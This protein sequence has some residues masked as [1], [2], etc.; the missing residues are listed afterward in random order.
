MIAVS[1][2]ISVTYASSFKLEDR[3]LEVKVCISDDLGYVSRAEVRFNRYG[4]NEGFDGTETMTFVGKKDNKSEFIAKKQI[5]D[6]G[7]ISF[8]I[9]VVINNKDKYITRDYNTFEPVLEEQKL[10][11]WEVF[12]YKDNYC[13]PEE[14]DG[15]I[16]YQVFVDTY[17]RQKEQSKASEKMLS[18]WDDP[19]QWKPDEKGDYYSNQF[20]GGNIKGIVSKLDHIKSL[21]TTALY[22]TPVLKSSTNHRYAT[23]DYEMVDE[24]VGLWEDLELLKEECHKRGMV[25]ILDIVFNHSGRYNRLMSEH[26]EMYKWEN[27]E[28]KCWWDF[29]ELPE[30]NQN[31][32]EF[33]KYVENWIKEHAKYVDGFRVDVADSLQDNVRKLMRRA[34][35]DKYFLYEVWK[36]AV[37]GDGKK[38]ID[39]TEGDAVMNY[40]FANAIYSYILFGNYHRAN[41]IIRRVHELYPPKAMNGCPIFLSS[42]DIPH[43]INILSGILISDRYSENVWDIDKDE[44]FTRNGRFDTYEFRKWESQHHDIPD[45]MKE[46]VFKRL[47]LA[48]LMEY[49][50]PGLPCIYNGEE[51]GVTG[52][53]DPFNRTPM[54]WKEFETDK[55]MNTIYSMYLDIGRF[56]LKYKEIFKDSTNFKIVRMDGRLMVYRRGNL[57]I[58]INRSDETVYYPY[59]SQNVVFAY[60][61]N[62]GDNRIPEMSAIVVKI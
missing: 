32:P 17:C 28:I 34:A 3:N 50:L 14:I 55:E 41:K 6:T 4:S 15:G 12:V 13:L 39:G 42:H 48:L 9:H 30:F 44:R 61:K 22:I 59:V 7:Y 35:P 27:G 49:T 47:K 46:I 31:N 21:G 43:V 16:M 54:P 33:Q 60:C 19:R 8:V 26:P 11:F 62:C 51:M 2:Q 10:A 1:N 53:R 52:Y 24:L 20:Y 58:I 25:L 56:R 29:K 37:T 38:F 23:D 36:N 57:E 5:H 45:S 40:P 18:N